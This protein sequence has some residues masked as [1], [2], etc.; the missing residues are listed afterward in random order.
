MV[1]GDNKCY[2]QYSG[3]SEVFGTDT[4]TL[5][6]HSIPSLN[7]KLGENCGETSFESSTSVTDYGRCRERCRSIDIRAMNQFGRT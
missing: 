6:H 2:D 4:A 5:I 7:G 3:D 1:A